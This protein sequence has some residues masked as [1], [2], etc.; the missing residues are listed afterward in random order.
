MATP[1]A[2]LANDLRLNLLERAEPSQQNLAVCKPAMSFPRPSSGLSH[3][4]GMWSTSRHA[5]EVRRG[6]VSCRAFLWFGG[7]RAAVAEPEVATPD[8]AQLRTEMGWDLYNDEEFKGWTVLGRGSYGTVFQAEDQRTGRTVA[9]KKIRKNRRKM[10]REKVLERLQ[11]ESSIL[12]ELQV[13]AAVARFH[14]RCEDEESAYLVME[15]I[16]PSDTLQDLMGARSG[17]RLT[18]PELLL[19]AKSILQFLAICHARGILYGDVKPANFMYSGGTSNVRV[20]DF[21]CSQRESSASNGGVFR[22][23]CGTPA[24]FA[25]EVFRRSFTIKADVWSLGMMLYHLSIGRFP[26]WEE[27]SNVTPQQVMECVTHESIPFVAAEWSH[28]SHEFQELV[29]LLLEKNPIH[30]PSAAEA[31]QHPSL[32]PLSKDYSAAVTGGLDEE[33]NGELAADVVLSQ[34][35]HREFDPFSGVWLAPQ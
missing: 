3:N 2:V 18:E 11:R 4:V 5:R 7:E 17:G 24:Y 35:L 21:G 26:F 34:S 22:T 10:T 14:R 19:V 20:I 30:R 16:T 6:S 25:P 29:T 8:E 15:R 32:A 9:V 23:R 33:L 12:Q 13:S 27:M 1:V 28:L 31:L